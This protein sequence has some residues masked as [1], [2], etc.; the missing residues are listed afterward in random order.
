MIIKMRTGANVLMVEA[1]VTALKKKGFDVLIKNGDGRFIIAAVGD[2]ADFTFEDRRNLA[3]IERVF[4]S[5]DIFLKNHEAFLE[6]W[7]FFA[8]YN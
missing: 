1:V 6:D 8:K 4:A 7:Q 3:G 2:G 5:N